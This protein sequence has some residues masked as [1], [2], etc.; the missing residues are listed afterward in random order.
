MDILDK[1]LKPLK[2][3]GGAT[4]VHEN[5]LKQ[6]SNM[7]CDPFQMVKVMEKAYFKKSKFA[8]LEIYTC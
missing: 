5:G 7:I 4:T 8:S 6:V 1:M 3:H 2:M